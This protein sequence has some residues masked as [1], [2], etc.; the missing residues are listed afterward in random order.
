MSALLWLPEPEAHDFSAALD[1]LTLVMD[2]VIA[3]KA[4]RALQRTATVSKKAK[5]ILRA[6]GL[7]VLGQ[8]N[9]H[10]RNDLR[11]VHNGDRLSPVLLVRGDAIAGR[12]LL[13]ADGYHRVCA[14]HLL[15]ED[16]EVPC[17]LVSMPV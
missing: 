5:D 12:P 9:V 3:K 14:A 15:D 16:A 6:S 4:V 1:Y 17:R 13:I 11:K 7:S 10:V 8:D 2:E